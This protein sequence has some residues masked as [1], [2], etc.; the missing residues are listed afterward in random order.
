MQRKKAH[1]LYCLSSV[2]YPAPPYY[3][4]LSHKRHDFQKNVNEQ[5]MC[6][7]IFS[8]NLKLFSF[9][10]ILS[11]FQRDIIIHTHTSSCKVPVILVTFLWNLTLLGIFSKNSQ[12][13]NFMTI[14]P[15]RAVLFSTDR[16]TDR[17][18]GRQIWRTK[19]IVQ[20]KHNN[21]FNNVKFATRFGYK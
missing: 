10:V 20:S 16:Q 11:R 5:R 7:L 1:A 2:A 17:Q 9:F 6:V 4:T 12:I 13:S 15:V 19:M 3:S 21:T 18:A 14:R 8:K